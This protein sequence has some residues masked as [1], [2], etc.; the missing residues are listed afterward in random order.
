MKKGGP[1]IMTIGMGNLEKEMIHLLV[2][3][4]YKGPFGVLGHVKEEDVAF[5]LKNNLKGIQSL[6]VVK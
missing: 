5:T 3:L 4:G 1:K 2:K 6:F